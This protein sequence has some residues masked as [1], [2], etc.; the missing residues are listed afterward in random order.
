MYDFL[1][2][3]DGNLVENDSKKCVMNPPGRIAHLE[4]YHV[5]TNLQVMSPIF[6][7]PCLETI[8]K[9]TNH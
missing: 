4:T 5:A 6:C 7:D 1:K 8:S 9:Y 3:G 2:D